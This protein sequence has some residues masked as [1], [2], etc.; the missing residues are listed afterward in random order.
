MTTLIEFFCGIGGMACGAQ[1]HGGQVVLAVDQDRA[2]CR[3]YQLNHGRAP[4]PRNI[5]NFREEDLLAPRADGWLLS[6]PCQPFTQKGKG[7][8]DQDP[9]TEPLL[10]LIDLL[11]RCRPSLLFLENV[12]PFGTSRTHARLLEALEEAR[13]H[14]VE[15]ELCPTDFGIPNRRRRYYLLACSAPLPQSA[16]LRPGR[17]EPRPLS[18]YLLPSASP[19]LVLQARDLQRL[20]KTDVI[21]MDGIAACFGSS[22][23]HALRRS[24]SYIAASDLGGTGIRRFSPEEILRFLH[25]PDDF[26]FPSDLTAAQRYRLAGNSVN[27]A[28]VR[29][30]LGVLLG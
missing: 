22:Y 25:F 14:V 2:A 10:H 3:T 26:S 11:P 13:L 12:P 17:R 20:A 21:P 19:D 24:G 4:L 15:T 27:V 30:L 7:L 5:C 9:R 6:P 16:A 29:H 23:G 1:A 8:D 18:A 28:V